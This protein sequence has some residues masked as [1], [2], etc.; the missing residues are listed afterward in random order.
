MSK[1]TP[2][3]PVGRSVGTKKTQQRSASYNPRQGPSDVKAGDDGSSLAQKKSQQLHEVTQGFSQA[4]E[5]SKQFSS[6]HMVR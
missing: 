4:C 3:G 1:S 5:C 2:A 6:S